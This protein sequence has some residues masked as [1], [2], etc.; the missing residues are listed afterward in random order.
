MMKFIRMKK[1]ILSIYLRFLNKCMIIGKELLSITLLVIPMEYV[2][3]CCYGS[4]RLNCYII[5]NSSYT[6]YWEKLF[7]IISGKVTEFVSSSFENR[8]Q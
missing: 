1:L 2:K 6:L 3:F 8:N 7:I 5:S 4:E